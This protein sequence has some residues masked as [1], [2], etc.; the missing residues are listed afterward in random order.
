[1]ECQTLHGLRPGRLCQALGGDGRQDGRSLLT[2]PFW[3]RCGTDC[4]IAIG[5]TI[6]ISRAVEQ[7][8]RL[9]LAGSQFFSRRCPNP[10][11]EA[12]PVLVG[13]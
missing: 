6:G 11:D 5:T 8:R 7:P 1:M 2:R 3:L 4:E 10:L 12:C 9:V 13:S